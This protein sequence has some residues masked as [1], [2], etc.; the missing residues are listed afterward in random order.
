MALTARSGRRT[1]RKVRAK[2]RKDAQ[3]DREIRRL[4]RRCSPEKKF[5]TQQVVQGGTLAGAVQA[6]NAMPQGA[7]NAL[8]LGLKCKDVSLWFK[9]MVQNAGSGAQQLCR[10]ILFKWF[11]AQAPT[12]GDIILNTSGG[13]NPDVHSANNLATASK[14]KIIYDRMFVFGR[15]V[16]GVVTASDQVIYTATVRKRLRGT[17]QY[18]DNAAA[19]DESGVVYLAYISSNALV[20]LIGTVQYQYTDA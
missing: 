3:Q 11:E 13:A 1:G 2:T 14:H 12:I 18:S 7:G 5:F 4:K 17:Q 6:I 9:Y 16:A 10:V 20:N 19:D 8:R 15:D